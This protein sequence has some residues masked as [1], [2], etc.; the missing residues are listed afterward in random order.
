[1]L[2]VF[3]ML[4]TMGLLVLAAVRQERHLEATIGDP[5]VPR[6]DTRGAHRRRRPQDS[7]VSTNSSGGSNPGR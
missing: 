3:A 1:M 7:W 6:P 4:L 2:L 5:R